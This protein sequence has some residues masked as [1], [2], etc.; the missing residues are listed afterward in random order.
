[1]MQYCNQSRSQRHSSFFPSGKTFQ[2]ISNRNF[3]S[4]ENIFIRNEVNRQCLSYSSID[5]LRHGPLQSN[6]NTAWHRTVSVLSVAR[7]IARP[8]SKGFNEYNTDDCPGWPPVCRPTICIIP[9]Q[10]GL[11]IAQ[12][13][14]S[15]IDHRC[16]VIL[17][18]V[19]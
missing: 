18:D 19:M 10:A 17:L 12:R 16:W 6:L 13:G 8:V 7:Y 14:I 3:H 4:K 15:S 2:V 11:V 9:D 5:K 1:M